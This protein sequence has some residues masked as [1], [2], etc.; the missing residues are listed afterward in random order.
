MTIMEDNNFVRL[1]EETFLKAN[2]HYRIRHQ[3][4][5]EPAGIR[6]VQAYCGAKDPRTAEPW[7]SK[8]WQ[9]KGKKYQDRASGKEIPTRWDMTTDGE[10]LCFQLSSSSYYLFE[11]E[12]MDEQQIAWA[13]SPP[14]SQAE[15]EKQRL[16]LVITLGRILV[17][18]NMPFEKLSTGDLEMEHRVHLR[19]IQRATYKH[20]P[21]I[22]QYKDSDWLRDNVLSWGSATGWDITLD[23]RIACCRVGYEDYYVFLIEPLADQQISYYKKKFGVRDHI[24][25]LSDAVKK[26]TDEQ[27]IEMLEFLQ[28]LLAELKKEEQE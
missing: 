18:K 10:L 6:L 15:M 13:V 25:D 24:D 16:D 5:Y 26:Y 2:P 4:H 20:P 21:H 1:L 27:G 19:L 9:L 8:E 12:A 7:K 14:L 22:P 28:L 17:S 23:G 3:G 11:V